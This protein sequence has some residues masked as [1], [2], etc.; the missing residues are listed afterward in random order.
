MS[1][2]SEITC[3]IRNHGNYYSWA[4]VEILSND[5]WVSLIYDVINDNESDRIKKMATPEVGSEIWL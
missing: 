5:P 4:K 3:Y 1:L 2:R